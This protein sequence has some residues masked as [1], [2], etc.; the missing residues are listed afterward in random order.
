M[1]IVWCGS[2]GVVWCGDDHHN[3]QTLYITLQLHYNYNYTTTTTGNDYGVSFEEATDYD[4]QVNENGDID[5]GEIA[6]QYLCLEL[7]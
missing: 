1:V 2:D 7:F 6:S 4:D 3:T 5:I